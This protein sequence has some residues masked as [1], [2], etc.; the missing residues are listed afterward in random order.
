MPDQRSIMLANPPPNVDAFIT[1]IRDLESVGCG[2][3]NI[4]PPAANLATPPTV[5]AFMGQPAVTDLDTVLNGFGDQLNHSVREIRSM[6]QTQPIRP[7]GPYNA[8]QSPSNLVTAGMGQQPNLTYNARPN[9]DGSFSERQRRPVSEIT[10]FNCNFKG[11]FAR[12]CPQTQSPTSGNVV[13]NYNL[14]GNE[15]AGQWGQDQPSS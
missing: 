9:F 10:C 3:S 12:D 7:N 1:R 5:A 13:A 15:M 8:I 6:L 4:N 11:H 2:L 14:S